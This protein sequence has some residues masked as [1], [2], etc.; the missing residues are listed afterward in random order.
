M[1]NVHMMF[2]VNMTLEKPPW[3]K[4]MREID[5]YIYIGDLKANAK[6]SKYTRKLIQSKLLRKL[7]KES[8]KTCAC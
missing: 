1:T 7:V 4:S 3:G 2:L 5:I 6:T 8:L